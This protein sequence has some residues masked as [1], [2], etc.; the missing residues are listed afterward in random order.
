M[1]FL[2]FLSR[3][4]AG[5]RAPGLAL[6][7]QAYESTVAS[8]PPV[9][10]TY[11]VAGNGPNVLD[12]LQQAAR[13]RSLGHLQ[14]IV[15]QESVNTLPAPSP[16]VPRFPESIGGRPSSAPDGPRLRSKSFSRSLRPDNDFLQK[17]LLPP[18]PSIPAQHRRR[19]SSLESELTSRFVDILDA[20]GEI[21]P[22]N[23]RSR[24]QATGAR[25][26][27]EDVAERNMV[28]S[29]NDSQ[30]P[31]VK[32]FY[33]HSTRSSHRV[34]IE[35]AP[36]DLA[37]SPYASGRQENRLRNQG[38]RE[39]STS[40]GKVSEASAWKALSDL[41]DTD[42]LGPDNA[43]G[44]RSERGH[45]K[46]T[47]ARHSNA[48]GIDERTLKKDRRRSFHTLACQR[49]REKIKPRPL[50]LHQS[51]A[52]FN[53]E[54]S[55]TPPLPN[56][57]PITSGDNSSYGIGRVE[58]ESC[59]DETFDEP[60]PSPIIPGRSR[61]IRHMSS[62]HSDV[63][64]DWQTPS[65]HSR[66]EK[67]H[68]SRPSSSS[69][70][71]PSR[72]PTRSIAVAR[73]D[74][75]T[76]HIPARTSSLGVQF[77]PCFTPTTTTSGYSSNPFPR[78]ESQHTPTTSIDAS[79]LAPSEKLGPD[80]DLGIS[81]QSSGGYQS[82]VYYT[83]PEE[84]D[85]S[86]DIPVSRRNRDD[87]QTQL[88]DRQ[89]LALTELS[90]LSNFAAEFT[91]D[92]DVDSFAGK[93]ERPSPIGE[94]GLLFDEGIYGGTAGALPGLFD[95]FPMAIA[96]AALERPKKAKST[97][98]NARPAS[99]YHQDRPRTRGSSLAHHP[100]SHRDDDSHGLAFQEEDFASFLASNDDFLRKA[101]LMRVPDY[102]SENRRPRRALY[103]Y[104]EE[105]E[106]EKVD[107]RTAMKLRKDL[108][109]IST[110][111]TTRTRQ[112]RSTYRPSHRDD[113]EGN[114]ADT[115]D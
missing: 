1:G 23:F 38:R 81:N 2:S 103:E 9:R 75:I 41:D 99:K 31:N 20:Q 44:S 13:K 36:S 39:V 18:V 83:A 88:E 45:R 34:V 85:F 7:A 96:P 42:M 74:D 32:S 82:P 27:G 4:P 93:F 57:Y 95:V 80:R 113:D 51:F 54:E 22:S 53:D 68:V 98:S 105:D 89:D 64:G 94:E 60:A 70:L 110:A 40:L 52:N 16:A 21:K 79:L 87:Y 106:E 8:H 30:S 11:P 5:D 107:T 104:E 72:P 58:V 76:E 14:Q 62:S 25:D 55:F 35:K 59:V 90:T 66:S 67:S 49:S 43:R 86:L 10:G 29:R 65:K 48:L 19:R 111:S 91:D 28:Q 109:R 6:K 15:R 47:E 63:L 84:D 102:E 56:F 101:G 73:L 97:R 69:S 46:R 26:Y 108:R 3:K 77:Q 12:K 115:E 92:S 37:K 112:S 78:P 50:S 61:T 33:A 71:D 114:A 17:Q 100:R 24:I